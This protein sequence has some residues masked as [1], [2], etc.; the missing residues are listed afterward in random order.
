MI[1]NIILQMPLQL[2]KAE[3]KTKYKGVLDLFIYQLLKTQYLKLNPLEQEKNKGADLFNFKQSD[4]ITTGEHLEMIGTQKDK[5]GTAN[6]FRKKYIKQADEFTL[7]LNNKDYKVYK[8]IEYNKG[9]L[10]YTFSDDFY[11]LL[12]NLYIKSYTTKENGYISGIWIN[13]KNL[14]EFFN[15]DTMMEKRIYLITIGRKRLKS[16][17]IINKSIFYGKYK[18]P[19]HIIQTE[20]EKAIDNIGQLLDI[21]IAIQIEDGVLEVLIDSGYDKG[22]VNIKREYKKGA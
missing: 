17:L 4:C 19:A 16:N 11:N 15:L 12:K 3:Y 21:F 20:I 8:N 13:S 22:S 7:N 9:I 18:K 5:N 10:L 6:Y 1:K 2:Q 14:K